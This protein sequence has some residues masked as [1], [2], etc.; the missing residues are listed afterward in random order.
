MKRMIGGQVIT[1]WELMTECGQH[2]GSWITP[3]EHYPEAGFC[4]ISDESEY[5]RYID[6]VR[7]EGAEP[8]DVIDAVKW[9]VGEA[10]EEVNE[11]LVTKA[12]YAAGLEEETER[13]HRL[14]YTGL[15]PDAPITENEHGGKQSVVEGRF[16]LIPPVAAFELAKVMEHGAEKYAPRNWMKIPVDSHLNHLLMHVFAYLAGDRQE[17]HLTH[18][19]ARASMAVEIEK[20]G[21]QSDTTM[22]DRD[23]CDF[24]D[25]GD[26][27]GG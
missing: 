23:P 6:C 25:Y 1:T 9:E 21:V 13:L 27:F 14:S 18:A 3:D 20:V 15:A 16:D 19:L 11:G 2:G 5:A 8:V 7:V 4:V 12:D 10:L 24:N 22:L 26:G 17:E